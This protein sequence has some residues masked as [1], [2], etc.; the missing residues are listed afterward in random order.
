M[1]GLHRNTEGSREGKYLVQRRDGT[2]PQWPWFVL[3]AADEDAADTLRDYANRVEK[4]GLDP[5][6]VADLRAMADDWEKRLK[7]GEWKK[8]D[9]DAPRHRKDDPEIIAKMRTAEAS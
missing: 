2:I 3:G 1:A 7:A 4:R 5:K 6:Y 8:G 9:P